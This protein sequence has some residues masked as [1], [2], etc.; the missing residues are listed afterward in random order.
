[1]ASPLQLR[2]E[3][4]DPSFESIIPEKLLISVIRIYMRILKW[5][6]GHLLAS[7]LLKKS[8]IRSQFYINNYQE[9]TFIPFRQEGP[10]NRGQYS[11]HNMLSASASFISSTEGKF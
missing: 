9:V 4:F 1:M 7:I 2:I 8:L 5:F 11:V 10:S 6:D 3:M